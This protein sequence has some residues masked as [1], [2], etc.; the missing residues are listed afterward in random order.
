M[1][2]GTFLAGSIP[3]TSAWSADQAAQY[4]RKHYADQCCK[5]DEKTS[6]TPK[7]VKKE[8]GLWER[9]ASDLKRI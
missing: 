5:H 1:V 6:H 7:A 9:V 4:E 3:A 2:T 8:G